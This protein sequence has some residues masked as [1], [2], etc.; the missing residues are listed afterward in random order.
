MVAVQVVYH[1]LLAHG[2][3]LA[4]VVVVLGHA[5]RGGAL[6]HHGESPGSRLNLVASHVVGAGGGRVLPLRQLLGGR[7]GEA[8]RRV[9]LRRDHF[10]VQDERG[11]QRLHARTRLGIGQRGRDDRPG[12]NHLTHRSH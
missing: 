4:T 11:A 9:H 8:L 6:V 3:S 5:Q 10:A 7:V 2:H 12:K 1:I